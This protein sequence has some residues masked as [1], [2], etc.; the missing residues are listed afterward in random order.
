MQYL[1]LELQLLILEHSDWEFHQTLSLVCRAWHSFILTSPSIW[2]NRY[3]AYNLP[4]DHANGP[5]TL[6]DAP[7]YH[8]ILSYLTHYVRMDDGVYRACFMRLAQRDSSGPYDRNH[9][10]REPARDMRLLNSAFFMD[11]PLSID[12]SSD[13]NYKGKNVV[14]REEEE[15]T[16]ASRLDF[17]NIYAHH[18]AAPWKWPQIKGHYVPSVGEFLAKNA[19]AVNRSTEGYYA[20]YNHADVLKIVM[21]YTKNEDTGR[22]ALE[23][24]VVPLS[25]D[26]CNINR[27][28]PTAATATPIGSMSVTTRFRR[29]YHRS[30]S[31]NNSDDGGANSGR[32][33]SMARKWEVVGKL[34]AMVKRRSRD[35]RSQL[36][37]LG[38]GG[39][40]D[41]KE[42]KTLF[43]PLSTLLVATS[44]TAV[45]DILGKDLGWDKSD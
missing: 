6:F 3:Q 40:Y 16:A 38:L 19:E 9:R 1:P 4:K 34:R 17:N 7:V 24:A 13:Y 35:G 2:R 42:L 30:S 11:D 15:E 23:F 22:C 20:N 10:D 33:R 25:R 32:T 45:A 28:L 29:H 39:Y 26:F 36:E 21:K 43:P 37:A 5:R 44:T 12:I 27:G 14:T 41:G 8:S 31:S 18:R